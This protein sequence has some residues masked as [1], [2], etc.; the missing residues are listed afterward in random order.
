MGTKLSE[1]RDGCFHKAMDDE[2]LFVLLARDTTAPGTI[3]SWADE[4]EAEVSA[5]KRPA[6]DLLQIAEARA[7]ADKMEK[8]RVDNDGAWRANNLFSEE[9]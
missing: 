7:T 6:S 5:G 9:G 2:P 1:L 3:R 4:R 8:W